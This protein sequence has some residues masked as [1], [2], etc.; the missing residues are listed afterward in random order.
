MPK[1]KSQKFEGRLRVIGRSSTRVNA[2]R[3]ERSGGV[4]VVRQPIIKKLELEHPLSEKGP[5]ETEKERLKK[6]SRKP[7]GRN[8]AATDTIALNSFGILRSA[9]V[10]FSHPRL[11]ARRG[12]V[13][14]FTGTQAQIEELENDKELVSIRLADTVRRPSASAGG[15]NLEPLASSLRSEIDDLS[16]PSVSANLEGFNYGE[17]VLVGIIDEGG[18][19]FA[20]PDFLDEDGNTRFVRIWDQAGDFRDPPNVTFKDAEGAVRCDYGAELTQDHLNHAIDV[21]S[22]VGLPPQMLEPQSRM[23]RGSHGTHVAS[24]AAGN[25]GVCRKAKIAGVLF[26]LPDEDRD[27]RLSFYDTTR[28]AHAIEYLLSVQQEVGAE[29]IV[30]NISLG[31]NGGAHDDSSPMSRWIDYALTSP[32]RV[33]CV[34]AGN[35]GQ[36][37]PR[38]AQD[39]GFTMGRIHTSGQ[40][41]ASELDRRLD[42]VVVGNGIE[43]I[44]ENELEIWYAPQDRIAVQIRPPGGDWTEPIEPNQFLKNFPLKGSRKTVLSVFNELYDTGNGF[45]RISIY[46]SPFVE[47]DSIIGIEPGVWSVRLIGRQIR[48]G[49]YHGWIERDNLVGLGRFGDRAFWSFPSFF[50]DGTNVDDS[51]LSTLGCGARVIAVA[52]LDADAEAI[53]VSSSQGPTRDGRQK[54]DICAPGTSILAANG[55]DDDALW[56]EKTGT[57]MA[58]PYVAGAVGLMLSLRPGMT[59]SQVLGILRRTAAP[60]PGHSFSWRNDTGF[61]EIQVAACLREASNADEQKE[62]KP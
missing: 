2:A 13:C 56:V 28:I 27:P 36:E 8:D 12:R 1:F 32:G 50:A 18:F 24:I 62:L 57:S 52:N 29:A 43:D 45:N 61:G 51:S 42:W 11:S 60:L 23:V 15:V 30:I 40:I 35:S 58:S 20:H 41:E 3:A 39:I 4:K 19:D 59:A 34:A 6:T 38:H 21:T 49:R 44:S 7:K 46:L 5:A 16:E 54:P 53:N 9:D 14:T 22:S 55:F 25:N 31:T 26:D 33:V 48:D 10:K 17:N 37:A 47:D